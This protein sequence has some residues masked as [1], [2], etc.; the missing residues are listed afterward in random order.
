[1]SRSRSARPTSMGPDQQ[2]GHQP[3]HHDPASQHAAAAAATPGTLTAATTAPTRNFV[4]GTSEETTRLDMVDSTATSRDCAMVTNGHGPPDPQLR[5]AGFAHPP[6]IVVTLVIAISLVTFGVWAW[7]GPE[8]RF[9]WALVKA[10]AVLII[11]CPCALRAKRSCVT[12]TWP[13]VGERANLGLVGRVPITADG[14]VGVTEPAG[15][16]RCNQ[17]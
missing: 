13:S 16:S 12:V 1:M 8:P 17:G 11:S 10:V 15:R 7:V 5:W 3:Q 9:A 14:P 2:N 4:T 6:D